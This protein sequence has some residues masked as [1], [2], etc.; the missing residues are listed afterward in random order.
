MK[1]FDI[2]K[3][4]RKNIQNLQ[5]YSSARNEYNIP[6]GVLLDANE[7]SFGS[8]ISS[9]LNRYPDPLQTELRTKL[10]ETHS[11]KKENVFVGNGSDEAIDLLI[12][13]FCDPHQDQIVICPPTYGIY[14]V[15]ARIN[16]VNVV[17]VPLT[18]DFQLDL[19]LIT[20][21]FGL[22][23]KIIFL[24]MPNNPTG[25][26]FESR[27]VE[28]IIES[29]GCLVAIDEAYAD[30]SAE[31]SWI[32]KLNR[33]PN[34]V[35]LRTLSKAWGLAG[36]RIGMAYGAPQII[37]IL[38]RIKF[39]YNINR[40]T[41]EVAIQALEKHQAKKEFVSKIISERNRLAAELGKLG[42]VEKVFPSETNFL[43]TRFIDSKNIFQH[44]LDKGIIV[45]DR[46][47]ALHCENCLRITVGTPEQNELLLATL[48]NWEKG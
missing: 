6:G 37:E 32:R 15:T 8:V 33:Y 46:S 4:A 16:D 10:A 48:T 43:L 35:I 13:A 22:A 41:Q 29:C 24:C 47:S 9:P 34:L 18:S 21:K 31:E 3:L 5:P 36:I 27:T 11:L 45:R 28:Q 42:C 12:R 30:F 19:I 40:L 25:N 1:K 2:K 23:T 26:Y 7:N 17:V 38:N 20:E 39:P 44:L 14:A